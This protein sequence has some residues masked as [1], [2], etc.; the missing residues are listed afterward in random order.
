VNLKTK[1]HESG[2]TQKEVA[3]LCGII[4]SA[5][6]HYETGRRHPKLQTLLKLSEIYEC[7]VDELLKESYDNDKGRA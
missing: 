6:S 5:Y 2:L 7:T 3:M 4:Q 1:R